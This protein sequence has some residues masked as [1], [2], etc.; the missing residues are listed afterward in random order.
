M[1]IQHGKEM[2][3]LTMVSIDGLED[4]LLKTI[5]AN[6]AS[7]ILKQKMVDLEPHGH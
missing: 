5:L 4:I 7:V 2:P 6:G 3:S 1:V